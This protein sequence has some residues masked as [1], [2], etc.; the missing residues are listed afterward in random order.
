[1]DFSCGTGADIRL[2]PLVYG[3]DILG[4]LEV[5]YNGYWGSVCDDLANNMTAD[6]AC[7]QLGHMEGQT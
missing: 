1:M 2:S 7:K 4:R 3:D 5:C 6:V